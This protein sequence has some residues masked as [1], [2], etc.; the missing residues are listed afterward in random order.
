MRG[1]FG[2]Q[3]GCMGSRDDVNDVFVVY[4]GKCAFLVTLRI[5]KPIFRRRRPDRV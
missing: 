5:G 1:S 4:W 3:A 2:R